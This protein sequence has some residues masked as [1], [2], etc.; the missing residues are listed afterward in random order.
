VGV[1]SSRP[2]MVYWALMGLHLLGEDVVP[3]RSRYIA[4]ATAKRSLK[5]S[6]RFADKA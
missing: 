3:F 5:G 6:Y 1:D 4:Q 2:W